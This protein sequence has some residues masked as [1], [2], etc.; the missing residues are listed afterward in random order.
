MSNTQ[1]H[2]SEKRRERAQQI[3]TTAKQQ[4]KL[5]ELAQRAGVDRDYL[6]SIAD[7]WLTP[8]LEELQHL[9]NA[10]ASL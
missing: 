1:F 6:Y 2:D 7:G 10:V 5:D 9:E 4:G 3:V 8:S